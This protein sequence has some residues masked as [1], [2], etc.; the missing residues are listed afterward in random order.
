MH[1]CQRM[2][3]RPV[4]SY[5]NQWEFSLEYPK[6]AH[7]GHRMNQQG[8][9][10]AR[11]EKSTVINWP[12]EEQSQGYFLTK[13]D[14][15]QWDFEYS[16]IQKS[17]KLGRCRNSSFELR[18]SCNLEDSLFLHNDF[19]Q[20]TTIS[21]GLSKSFLLFPVSSLSTVCSMVKRNHQSVICYSSVQKEPSV[22]NLL[23][24]SSKGT[25]NQ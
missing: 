13:D 25:T 20:G 22:S 9:P 1:P 5:M 11:N 16:L 18:S 4:P 21:F 17:Q 7:P 12:Q 23:L 3:H 10:E 2:E 8:R 24:L 15:V 14:L 19:F 6:W